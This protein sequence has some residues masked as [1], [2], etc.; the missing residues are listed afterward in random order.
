MLI[1]LLSP[2]LNAI[3]IKIVIFSPVNF[4]Y[5][6][7]MQLKQLE[8]WHNMRGA[9]SCLKLAVKGCL[10]KPKLDIIHLRTDFPMDSHMG[11]FL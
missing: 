3:Q 2:P 11:S 9:V 8:Q 1:C 7:N 10:C 5:D 4:S 6:F